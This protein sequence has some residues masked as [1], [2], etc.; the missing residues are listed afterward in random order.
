MASITAIAICLG[1]CGAEAQ[2]ASLQTVSTPR[3]AKQSFI[4]IKPEKP[5]AAVILF[6]GG[7]GGL[8][9]SGPASMAWGA[10]NFLVRTHTQFAAQNFL[11]AVADA[12][13]DQA[14]GMNAIFRM[15]GD[16][17]GDIGAIAAY[18]KAQSNLPV[19]LVGTSMGTFSAA[20]GAIDGKN[21]DG[22]I[23]TSTITRANPNWKIANSHADGVASMALGQ[24]KVPTLVVAH[25]QDACDITPASDV[26]K[27]TRKLAGTKKVEVALL[28]GGSPPQ[29]A[30]CDAKSQHGFLGIE[31]QA[32]SR[33]AAFIK[34]NGP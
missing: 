24:V 11:V 28:E 23:L 25:K 1:V 21:I 22:L 12:P 26:P 9:L 18:L 32:I 3:G 10:G 17:A 7:H 31:G 4:L 5:V 27:L 29:S 14:G 6:A 2:T 15:S 33:I 20:R 19:W 34:A 13:S 16:H 8:G 30:P